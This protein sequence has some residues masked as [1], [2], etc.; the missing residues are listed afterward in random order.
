MKRKKNQ[1]KRDFFDKMK[2]DLFRSSSF[3][4]APVCRIVFP[5]VRGKCPRLGKDMK[6]FCVFQLKKTKSMIQYI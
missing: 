3:F 2:G 5:H 6:V 1:E 4:S